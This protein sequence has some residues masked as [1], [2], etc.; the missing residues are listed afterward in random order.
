M[1]GVL[2]LAALALPAGVHAAPADAAAENRVV[3]FSADVRVDVD[4]VG[5]PLK[6]EAPQDLPPAIRA[7]IEKRVASWQYQPANI[8]GVAQA[9]TTYVSVHACA[10]PVPEGYRLG[11]DFV[12]NGPRVAAGQVMAPP[13]YPSAAM[14]S[15][16]EA[17]FSLIL[18]MDA[19][20]HAVIDRIDRLSISRHARAG[21]FEL[22]LRRWA[23]ALRFDPEMVAGKAVTTDIRIPVD[24][25]SPSASRLRALR[26]ELQAKAQASRECR[27]AS[28]DYDMRPIA[29]Q[30]AVTVI[31]RPPG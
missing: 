20:G 22:V 21:D 15:G 17:A 11:V 5:K 13:E 23:K 4:A 16:Y 31:P 7:L 28:G 10:V 25:I 29:L 30:P 27:I 14:R 9:A 24:F 6:V 8:G 12:G 2:L 3:A 18:K 1:K 19:D 26:G